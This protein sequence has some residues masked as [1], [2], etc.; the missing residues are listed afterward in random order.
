[1]HGRFKG[2]KNMLK[3]FQPKHRSI[4]GIDITSTAVKVLEI[5]GQEDTFVVENYGREVLPAN[6]MDGNTIKDVDAVSQCIKKVIDRLH[7]PCKQAA[8]AV[9]DSSIISKVIQINEGL[10]DEEME[11]LIV[12]E[13]DKYIPYPIDEI[14]L[15][16]EILG[17][18]EKNPSMLDVLIVAS[19]AEN[20]NQR[21]ETAVHA[22]LEVVV[23]DVESHA[24]ERAAQ[25]LA[26]DLS[27][28]GQDKTIAIIDIGACYT[29]L[30]VLQGMKL[31]YSREEKFGGKQLIDSIAEYYAM[32][33]EQA[34]LA[35]DNGE[36]PADYE[37]KVLDPFKENILLQI[38]RTLQFFYSTSQDGEVDHI[39]LSGGLA[40]LPGLVALIQE[41]L[42]MSTTIANPF[43]YMTPG[44]I[45]NLDSIKHDAPALMVA[46]GLALRDIK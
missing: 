5:S 42:G 32:S 36:L 34:A 20:V 16:F 22:G 14:N 12:T 31:V 35:K 29:H 30:F 4:L 7:T 45:V 24:V 27:A 9:P 11:E 40:K 18:S 43:S 38:K 17:H 21:V 37:E 26:K 33:L 23:I 46:C 1:M 15:D 2:I 44:K 28:S 39:L 3:L 25:Q 41:R 10:N 8:L 13:A 19:R 6:A